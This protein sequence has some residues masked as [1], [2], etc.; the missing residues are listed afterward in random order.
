MGLTNIGMMGNPYSE[1]AREI[2]YLQRHQ[3]ELLGIRLLRVF[4]LAILGK[5][6]SL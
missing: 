1:P 2:E 5:P 3:G 6:S 4:E